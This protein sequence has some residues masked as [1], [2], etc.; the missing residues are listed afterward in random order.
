MSILLKAFRQEAWD[1]LLGLANQAVP[2]APQENAEWL[3]FRKAFDETKYYRRHYIAW[4]EEQPIGYGC[5]EQQSD[6]AECLRGFVV[7]GAE[8]MS[9]GVGKELFERLLAD[10]KGM[11]AMH[12]WAREYEADDVARRFF[13]G[14]GFQ[15]AK[16][17]TPPGEKPVVVYTY[18]VSTENAAQHSA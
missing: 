4:Q 3:E 2:F 9:T 15:E 10:A 17:F 7:C 1:L 16:R 13:L 8:R 5:V 6:D 18:Q 11:G 12:L 14:C